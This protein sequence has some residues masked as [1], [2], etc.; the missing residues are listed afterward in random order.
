MPR[1]AYISNF[2][3]GGLDAFSDIMRMASMVGT[4][5]SLAQPGLT[6]SV[7]FP[8]LTAPVTGF[9]SDGQDRPPRTI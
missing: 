2:G 8:A 1:D 3:L 5:P 4:V 9:Q 7:A 6:S